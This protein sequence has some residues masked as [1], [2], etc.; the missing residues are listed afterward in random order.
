VVTK[1]QQTKH[2][3]LP[4]QVDLQHNA[5]LHALNATT[6]RHIPMNRMG[7]ICL[8]VQLQQELLEA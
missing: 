5:A 7:L 3:A 1:I 2:A 8:C 4:V 6:Q